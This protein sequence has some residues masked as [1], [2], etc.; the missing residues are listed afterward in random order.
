LNECCFIV[1]HVIHIHSAVNQ[2]NLNIYINWYTCPSITHY[3]IFRSNSP[4]L[5]NLNSYAILVCVAPRA[6]ALKIKINKVMET[7]FC[8]HDRLVQRRI[9][10]S[11]RR[12]CISVEQLIVLIIIIITHVILLNIIFIQLYNKLNY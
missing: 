4:L 12:Y 7:L 11:S 2:V 10:S 1:T 6:V 8:L 3:T 5:T 9:L